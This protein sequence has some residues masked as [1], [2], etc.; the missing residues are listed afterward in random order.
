MHI[1]ATSD[2]DVADLSYLTWSHP[3][4]AAPQPFYTLSQGRITTSCHAAMSD[5]RDDQARQWTSA[6]TN[7]VTVLSSDAG[8]ERGRLVGRQRE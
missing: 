3:Q 8:T 4:D 1:A 5:V 6:T 7:A 2:H